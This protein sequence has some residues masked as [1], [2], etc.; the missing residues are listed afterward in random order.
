ML[1]TCL[2]YCLQE[3][4]GFSCFQEMASPADFEAYASS[5]AAVQPASRS[6]SGQLT[7]F[8]SAVLL[9]VAVCLLGG[10]ALL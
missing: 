6:G 2:P 1:H 5:T 3:G 7:P 9:Y 10:W 8:S 4:K